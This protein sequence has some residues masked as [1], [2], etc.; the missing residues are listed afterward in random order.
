MIEIVNG[1]SEKKNQILIHDN[2]PNMWWRLEIKP[3]RK[4]RVNFED[5]NFKNTKVYFMLSSMLTFFSRFHISFSLAIFS[6]CNFF[7]QRIFFF[8]TICFYAELQNAR[9]KRIYI[10]YNERIRRVGKKYIWKC[11]KRIFQWQN[12]RMVQLFNIT[13]EREKKRSNKRENSVQFS[14]I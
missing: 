14:W 6:L 13:R 3:N 7:P 5:S 1:N 12:E 8:C 2:H 9:R 11:V 10:P 4:P